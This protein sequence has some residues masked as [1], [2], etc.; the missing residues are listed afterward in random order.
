M[1]LA[2]TGSLLAAGTAWLDNGA[3]AGQ[4][5]VLLLLP[6]SS[7]EAA[8]ALPAAASQY[9]RSQAAAARLGEIAL[10]PTAPGPDDP[11]PDAPADT[12]R[13]V[14]IDPDRAHLRAVGLTA[15][16]HADAPRIRDLDLVLRPGSRLA[17]TGASGTGKSTLLSTL[18]GLLDPLAGRVELD[19]HDLASLPG[20]QVRQG[21]V[22]FAEDAHVFATTVREN[23]RVVRADVDDASASA[24]LRAVG[25]DD[26]VATLPRGL[27]TMLGPD[28]TTVS[29]GERRR[30]LL[31]RSV[32][33][34]G[35]VLLL[36]GPTEHLDTARGDA[37]LEALLTPGDESL[38]PASTTVVVVTHR[39]EATAAQTAVLRI[40]DAGHTVLEEDSCRHCHTARPRQRAQT[41][42]AS[43]PSPV[44]YGPVPTPKNCWTC[45]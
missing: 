15:G 30:L 28:G 18:A 11:A 37:L 1:I 35:P 21:V 13:E 45:W 23:L 22:M 26:W 44:R 29:G 8:T 16:W 36:D 43:R 5:G 39:L 12:A 42:P 17:V 20:R 38:V 24:A 2:V 3:S 33:R 40:G 25:L 6:L 9:A 41:A 31:A 34:R 10:P 32:L 19:G 27:D 7:F 4:V 14:T